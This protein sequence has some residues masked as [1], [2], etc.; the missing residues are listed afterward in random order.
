MLKYVGFSLVSVCSLASLN[1]EL[2]GLEHI[3]VGD[4]AGL[5]HKV[6]V[7]QI[8]PNRIDNFGNNLLHYAVTCQSDAAP[9]IVRLL[10]KQGV[11]IDQKNYAGK[12]PLQC[13]LHEIIAYQKQY[14]D[15]DVASMDK[16]NIGQMMLNQLQI[17][18]K[19]IFA[20]R[21]LLVVCGA[22]CMH[23]SEDQRRALIID[24]EELSIFQ[25][26]PNYMLLVDVLLTY[27][28]MSM[29]WSWV[30]ESLELSIRK[31]ID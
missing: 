29:A 26:C 24:S 12:T 19:Q 1:Q 16:K 4:F 6:E 14:N 20:L 13:C 15:I 9:D 27:G 25:P 17:R 30:Q 8:D 22:D 31:F 10:I 7:N 21:D 5:K 18:Y 28:F 11:A 23:L 2:E 3:V